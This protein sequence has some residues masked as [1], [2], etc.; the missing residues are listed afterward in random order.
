MID[1]C[2]KP[3]RSPSWIPDATRQ[4]FRIREVVEKF[5]RQEVIVVFLADETSL[6]GENFPR[7][8]HLVPIASGAGE[9]Q[10]EL[11]PA[12]GVLGPA[13]AFGKGPPGAE[14]HL[15]R[16]H[17]DRFP[18]ILHNRQGG[19]L[20]RRL[21]D[22]R[23]RPQLHRRPG[24]APGRGAH[25]VLR[26]RP[27]LLRSG[28][29]RRA[30]EGRIRHGTLPGSAGVAKGDWVNRLW[31]NEYHDLYAWIHPGDD[32]GDPLLRH[33]GAVDRAKSAAICPVSLL[34]AIETTGPS[35][36]DR[37]RCCLLITWGSK[38]ALRSQ[39]MSISTGPI[40][41]STV[42]ER[43]PLWALPSPRAG[44]AL[45]GRPSRPPAPHR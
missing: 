4:A 25:L 17:G 11:L 24:P 29:R 26:L 19:L 39:G 16:F 37:R 13:S 43:F 3:S 23:V 32:G 44:R 15:L 7:P 30:G 41:V 36:P 10:A 18:T 31:A 8:L 20:E 6:G 28:D 40:L 27:G 21:G 1:E 9:F 33:A 35:T 34:A 45:D 14:A 38:L 12:G 22:L 42:L 5:H 2:V